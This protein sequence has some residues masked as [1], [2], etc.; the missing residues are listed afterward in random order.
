MSGSLSQE[1][2]SGQSPVLCNSI[3]GFQNTALKGDIHSDDGTIIFNEWNGDEIRPILQLSAY[4]GA[5][6][7]I[8]VTG[9]NRH[10]FIFR[11]KLKGFNRVLDDIFGLIGC[12]KDTGQIRK[13]NAV[14]AVCILMH[15]CKIVFHLR[16]LSVMGQVPNSLDCRE[17]G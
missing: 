6:D 13:L 1:R 12:G 11:E 5:R 16:F 10:G 7:D 9:C 8:C 14:G 17:A 3:D 4:I 15:Q 2:R